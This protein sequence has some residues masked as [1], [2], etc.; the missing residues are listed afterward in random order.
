MCPVRIVPLK[1]L[2]AHA[3]IVRSDRP[4]R[5]PSPQP[6][7]HGAFDAQPLERSGP[8]AEH[9]DARLLR[10]ARLGWTHHLRSDLHISARRRLS[11]YTRYLV[12][13][14]DRGLAR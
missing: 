2:A 4:R 1:D 6:H 3:D 5:S 11:A 10:A 7:S 13:R 14:T 12:A 9:A 8:C